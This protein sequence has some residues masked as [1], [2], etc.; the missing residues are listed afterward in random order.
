MAA[1]LINVDPCLVISF[2]L[3]ALILESLIRALIRG[4]GLLIRGLG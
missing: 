1:C 2:L 4:A 3:R